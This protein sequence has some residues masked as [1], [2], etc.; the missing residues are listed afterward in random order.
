MEKVFLVHVN[1]VR[2]LP[3]GIKEQ[4]RGFRFFPGEGEAPLREIIRCF[5]EG[6]YKNYYCVELFN[7]SYWRADPMTTLEKAKSS[8][9]SLF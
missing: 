9:E 6:G 8:L 7:E 5:V 3:M 4:S 1:D 2:S